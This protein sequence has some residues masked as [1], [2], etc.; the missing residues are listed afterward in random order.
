MAQRLPKSIPL[1]FLKYLYDYLQVYVLILCL[2]SFYRGILRRVI[3]LLADPDPKIRE[4]SILLLY[5]LIKNSAI[6]HCF[7]NYVELL[8]LKLFET[9]QDSSRVVCLFYFS[10]LEFRI[11]FSW[12]G[13]NIVMENNLHQYKRGTMFWLNQQHTCKWLPFYR[14]T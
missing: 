2:L 12:Q 4:A 8:I 3:Q 9:I 14:H 5:S 6:T 13:F 7:T 11:F 10:I 1:L